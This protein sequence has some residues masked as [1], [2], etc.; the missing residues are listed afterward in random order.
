M[1]STT[2]KIK[3]INCVLVAI[4]NVLFDT[5]TKSFVKNQR[6]VSTIRDFIKKN[7]KFIVFGTKNLVDIEATYKHF[8]IYDFCPYS[9]ACNGSLI[10]DNI[11]KRKISHRYLTRNVIDVSEELQKKFNEQRIPVALLGYDGYDCVKIVA[12]DSL[13][14]SDYR[15]IIKSENCIGKN[16]F[17]TVNTLNEELPL[18]KITWKFFSKSMKKIDELYKIILEHFNRLIVKP[19]VINDLVNNCVEVNMIGNQKSNAFTELISLL[20]ITSE[21]CML[22][23]NGENDVALFDS[24]ETSITNECGDKKTKKVN[25][26]IF[27][28]SSN[29]NL[30][31]KALS[32]LI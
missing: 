31:V 23:G 18:V 25:A 17:V 24:I 26:K 14:K 28:N 13:S 30:V 3:N 10:Y 4:D 27:L 8:N 5:K 12:N 9:I 2:K 15:N 11:R 16:N 6:L 19:V 20:N 22:I 7:N 32:M 29:D 1:N 21:S